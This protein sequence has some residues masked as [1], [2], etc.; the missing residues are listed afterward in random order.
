MALDL[1]PNDANPRNTMT[2]G[3]AEAFVLAVQRATGR[4]PLVYTHPAWANGDTYG[5]RRLS[6]GATVRPGSVLA[7]CDL[8]LADYREDPQIPFAWAD[9]G[10]RLWQYAADETQAN[11]AHGSEKRAVA[12]VGHCDRNLFNGDTAALHRYWKAGARTV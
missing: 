2:L 5:R 12:G 11:F 4:L 3:Q 9:R 8:W 1:E 6:L 10:W 7:R